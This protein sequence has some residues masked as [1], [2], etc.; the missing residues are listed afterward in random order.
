MYPDQ[1]RK[2]LEGNGLFGGYGYQNRERPGLQQ[3]NIDDPEIKN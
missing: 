1:R 3:K 2:Y